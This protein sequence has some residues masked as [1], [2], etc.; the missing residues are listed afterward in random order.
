M[1]ALEECRS[2]DVLR[3]DEFCHGEGRFGTSEKRREG[4][5]A[6][7]WNSG[8]EQAAENPAAQANYADV[9]V[10]FGAFFERVWRSR[11]RNLD[12]GGPSSTIGD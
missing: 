10:V 9:C 1:L 3:V 12:V 11:V 6:P 2:S 4:V 7:G 8:Y 5:P